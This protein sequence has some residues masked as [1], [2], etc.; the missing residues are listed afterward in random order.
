V[1]AKVC[2]YK[3]ADVTKSMF[4]VSKKGMVFFSKQINISDFYFDETED[5]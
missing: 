1:T 5:S 2:T 3:R 4:V